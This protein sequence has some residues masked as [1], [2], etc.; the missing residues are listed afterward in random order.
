MAR[1]EVRRGRTVSDRTLIILL[2]IPA[3]LAFAFG[4]WAGLGYPGVYDKYQSTG[5]VPREM[6]FKRLLAWF[7]R[8]M[9]GGPPRS[10]GSSS[11]GP[12]E[13]SRRGDL[14]GRWRR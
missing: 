2:A 12:S 6:P 8:R 1:R 7:G 14:R 4:M 9:G 10:G 13:R 5:R 3:I 11:S